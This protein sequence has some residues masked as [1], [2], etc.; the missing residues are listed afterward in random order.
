MLRE[1][2]THIR[3]VLFDFGGVIAEE[4]FK[5]GLRAL[6]K[7]QQLDPDEVMNE[8]REAVH[9][10]GYVTGTGT[11][12]DFWTLLRERTG[13]RG[14]DKELSQA[15]LDRF[16]VRQWMIEQ[17][18]RLRNAGLIVAILS[19]QTDWL[20]YLDQRLHFSAA[21]DRVFNSFHLG[22]SKCDPTLFDD[23]V[24]MLGVQPG[25]TLFVDDDAGHVERARNCGLHAIHFTE[26]DVFEAQLLSLLGESAVAE[27]SG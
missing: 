23:A 20:D 6:A 3:A 19:D 13:L 18:A 25:E 17:V 24:Q 12:A 9:D 10:S 14:E 22:K 11:E 4:G 7:A 27:Q 5:Q 1:T 16:I 15:I 2:P 8:G 21:F 26:R